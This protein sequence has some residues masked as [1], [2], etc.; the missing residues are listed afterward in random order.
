MHSWNCVP[1]TLVTLCW[2]FPLATDV[3][4]RFIGLNCFHAHFCCREQQFHALWHHR[5]ES[6]RFHIDVMWV[7]HIDFK[8]KLDTFRLNSHRY[9]HSCF[10]TTEFQYKLCPPTLVVI[11]K[12]SC[13]GFLLLATRGKAEIMHVELSVTSTE[14][15]VFCVWFI[16]VYFPMHHVPTLQLM[17]SIYTSACPIHYNNT[18]YHPSPQYWNNDTVILSYSMLFTQGMG[19]SRF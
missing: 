3:S 9:E 14:E 5:S 2:H 19:G 18:T 4:K 8:K 17:L 13:Q 10:V 11:W 16:F 1:L 12:W 6:T 15:Y 7:F